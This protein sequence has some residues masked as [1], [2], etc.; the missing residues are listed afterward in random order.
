MAGET[1]G[2]KHPAAAATF[3]Q[4]EEGLKA[5][6]QVDLTKVDLGEGE[7]LP[8]ELKGKTAAELLQHT[9][10]L[11]NAVK[12][13]EAARK[14]QAAQM[15]EMTARLAAHQVAPAAV[16][17]QEVPEEKELTLDEYEKLYEDSPLKAM[18]AMTSAAEKRLAKNLD[19]RMVPLTMGS[20]DTAEANAR[21]TY[22][23][24]FELFKPDI[25]AIISRLPSKASL[26]SAKAWDDLISYVRGQPGNMEKLFER[27]D[28]STR[29]EAEK[30]AQEAEAAAAG[31]SLSGGERPPAAVPAGQLDPTEKEIAKGL[32]MSD[33]DYLKWKKVG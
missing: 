11:S 14:D 6:E 31:V 25:D 28:A 17:P 12:T 33:A 10:A 15:T 21:Q 2:T 19:A 24:E 32:G 20:A 23:V 9:I 30:K 5:P 4:I 26:S 18:V 22:K 7:D 16:V 29:A 27:R 3:D 8:D 1:T 13:S